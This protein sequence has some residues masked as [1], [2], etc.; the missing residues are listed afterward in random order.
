[1]FVAVATLP[2]DHDRLYL[3]WT[4]YITHIW[5]RREVITPGSA[6]DRVDRHH[7]L[8]M[9]GR[10]LAGTDCPRRCEITVGTI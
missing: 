5:H 8:L 7:L 3:K 10:A 6:L 2:D 1:M 9:T 4:F